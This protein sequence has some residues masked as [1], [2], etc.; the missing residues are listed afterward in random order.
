MS[1]KIITV[2]LIAAIIVA[3]F[4][5]VVTLGLST[6]TLPVKEK[7]VTIIKGNDMQAANVGLTI[8]ETSLA[9]NG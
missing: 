2:L 5:M 8:K 1:E 4:S 3:V 9:I 6:D 7:T